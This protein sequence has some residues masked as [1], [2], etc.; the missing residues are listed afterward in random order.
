MNDKKLENL[1]V[2]KGVVEHKDDKDLKKKKKVEEV[3]EV[4]AN[5]PKEEKVLSV[6]EQKIKDAFAKKEV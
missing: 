6:L 2:S 3:E 1:E 5:E 4:D